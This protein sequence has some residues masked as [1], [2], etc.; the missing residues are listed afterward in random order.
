MKFDILCT[1]DLGTGFK[2]RK[3]VYDNQ[4]S[5]IFDEDNN[6][7]FKQPATKKYCKNCATKKV[8]RDNPGVKTGSNVRNLKIQL[9]LSCNYSC[10]Y[11]SQRF[12]PNADE[13][14]HKNVDKFMKNLD[15]W[16]HNPP[17]KIEFWGGEPLVYWKTLKPLAEALREKFPDVTFYMIT[18]G[19]L[20]TPE[21]NQWIV[22]MNMDIS[23]SHDGPGQVVRGP[24][25]FEDPASREAI[26]D[27]WWKKN[28]NMSFNSMA[29]RENMDRKKIAE[30]FKERFGPK[31][32][33]G[34]GAYI[35]AYDEGGLKNTYCTTEE[36]YAFRRLTMHQLREGSL[37]NFLFTKKRLQD[38]LES[39]KEFRPADVVGQKCGMDRPDIIAVDLRGNVLTCQNVSAVST[40]DNGQPHLIGH[41]SNMDK[42]KL[43]TSTHW[44]HR[45]D[46][47]KCP[48]LQ[49]CK[50]SCM[51]L[52]DEKFKIS[53]DAA[54]SDHLPFFCAAF[55][56]V[57]GCLPF[58][59][60]AQD[61]SLPEERAD[62]W[63]R[64]SEK[65]TIP[66]TRE[67]SNV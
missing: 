47:V 48:L 21:I 31:V 20:L 60:Q 55:E 41:V 18:N 23:I 50:G 19:S 27:L 3:F 22:D 52:D 28:G 51:F 34:E 44:S 43:N 33:I 24:D 42:V 12:V 17:K 46:C 36:F 26:E 56:M 16:L 45:E 6:P 10:E 64:A 32:V 37:H 13:T 14:S 59:I 35:D 9:G 65:Y 40:K 11:C 29:H 39:F 49:G 2:I 61:N 30:F 5:E 58:A 67:S 25:P 57:T 62:L 15:L 38:W 63:G 66:K 8:S 1:Q 53:C 4:T 54:Y 7:I